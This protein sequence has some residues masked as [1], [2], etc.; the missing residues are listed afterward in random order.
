M[1]IPFLPFLLLLPN[2]FLLNFML[3]LLLMRL[4]FLLLFSVDIVLL[5]HVAAETALFQFQPFRLLLFFA[6]IF[7]SASVTV[8]VTVVPLLPPHP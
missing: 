3:L 5:L 6:I 7:Y 8:T 2:F 1:L 4:L